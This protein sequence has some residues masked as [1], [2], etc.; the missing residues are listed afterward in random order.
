[1]FRRN[2]SSESLGEENGTPFQT[3]ERATPVV[4]AQESTNTDKNSQQSRKRTH[5][6]NTNVA[7]V[8]CSRN[9]ASCES[10]RPCT[11]CIKKGIANTC[12]D[13]PRKKRKYLEGVESALITR[14]PSSGNLS[15]LN[16]NGGIGIHAGIPNGMLQAPYTPQ[17]QDYNNGNHRSKFL[18][19][20]ADSEYSILSNIIRQDST[21]KRNDRD[22]GQQN[23]GN[24]RYATYTGPN[25]EVNTPSSASHTPNAM[26][27]PQSLSP[28]NNK[29]FNV[30]ITQQNTFAHKP[31]QP[32]PSSNM[33]I[34]SILLGPYGSDIVSS[35]VNLYA[36]HFPLVPYPTADGTINFKRIYAHDP[37]SKTEKTDSFYN[38]KINQYYLNNDCMTLPELQYKLDNNK[39]EKRE[40]NPDYAMS[41]SLECVPPDIA[42]PYNNVE[43][44]HSLKYATPVEIYK[45]INEPFSHTPGFRHL[46]IYLRKRFNQRD[47]VSMCQSMAYFRPIF[48]ACS[49]ALTEEDMIFMEQCYQRTLLQYVKFIHEIG[50]PT[51]VWRRN[52]QI[53]YINDE[54]EI[55]TGWKRDELLNKMTFIVEIMD[56]ESVREYFK[57]FSRVAYNNIKG[58]EQMDICRL[59]SP[60]KGQVIECK[61]M[62]TLKRDMSGL[63]LMILG[64]FMPIL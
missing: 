35:H 50:T 62:W 18:S 61:C 7:C 49:I 48:I 58:S 13:A 11:R 30:D 25:S 52:G 9:H 2:G 51:C 37:L 54:F 44:D 10:K 36:N 4:A 29:V 6:K 57:T 20:A 56:D 43:W 8:N 41:V 60:I 19:N 47:L 46:L 16:Y 40:N 32:Y 23:Y 53:S 39:I 31:P 1:M 42:R 17:Y 64:N 15:N 59:L 24:G 21:N 33:N 5:K 22:F 27:G 38:S 45:L 55:L 3:D 14:D 28:G 12:I 63:P 34:Y 26:N